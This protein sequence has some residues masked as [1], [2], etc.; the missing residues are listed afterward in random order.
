MTGDVGDSLHMKDFE[1][2][3]ARIW[4]IDNGIL[5][6]CREDKKKGNKHCLKRR[7]HWKET[8]KLDVTQK[9]KTK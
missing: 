8:K 3:K 4:V 9:V 5:D 7:G 2:E 6:V 1:G